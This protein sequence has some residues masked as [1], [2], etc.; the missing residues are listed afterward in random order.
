MSLLRANPPQPAYTQLLAGLRSLQPNLQAT[1]GD[2][3]KCKL[4]PAVVEPRNTITRGVDA[5]FELEAAQQTQTLRALVGDLL[6]A[7]QELR[8]TNQ[9]LCEI[10]HQ[11]S[12]TNQE[13]RNALREANRSPQ[14]GD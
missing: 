2:M 11:L 10:N 13:L 3:N 8:D 14:P 9:E 7:N 5:S 1:R 6:K 4:P 12:A